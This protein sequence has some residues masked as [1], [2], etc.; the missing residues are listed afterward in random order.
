MD[1]P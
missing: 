1:L